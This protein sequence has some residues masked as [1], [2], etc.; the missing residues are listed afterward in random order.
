MKYLDYVKTLQTQITITYVVVMIFAVL[1]GIGLKWVGLI[2]TIPI[3]LWICS[4]YTI[5]QKIKIEEMKWQIDLHYA[6]Y[7][8]E[9]V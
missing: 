9:V 1:I 4:W 6:I 5:R 2:L 3:G 8:K 7:K